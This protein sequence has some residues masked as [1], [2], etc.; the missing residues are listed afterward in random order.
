[1]ILIKHYADAF[2][3][4]TSMNSLIEIVKDSMQTKELKKIQSGING[5]KAHIDGN[6]D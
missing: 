3:T 6:L 1:M 2:K 5:I 4:Y